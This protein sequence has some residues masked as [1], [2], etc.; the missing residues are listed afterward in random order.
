MLELKIIHKLILKM[1][2][3]FKKLHVWNTIALIS[4]YLTV[5]AMLMNWLTEGLK[6]FAV[7]ALFTGLVVEIIFLMEQFRRK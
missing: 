7:I 3:A 5:I 1:L 2:Q 6:I 4:L